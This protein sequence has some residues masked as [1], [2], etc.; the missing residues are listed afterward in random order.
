MKAAHT[1]GPWKACGYEVHDRTTEYDEDGARIGS[2][3][4]C[5]CT[6]HFVPSHADQRKANA[7]LIAAA[8]ELLAAL[9]K[10]VEQYGR[11]GGPWNVPSTP[12]TWIADAQAAIAKA[13]SD[14]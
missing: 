11:P 5:I 10:A 2:T 12:G 14:A 13:V 3:A 8:P 6:A 9:E 7:A 4:N 1:P